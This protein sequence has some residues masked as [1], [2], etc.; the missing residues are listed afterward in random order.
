MNRTTGP[1]CI[2]LLD[3]C[4]RQGVF[5]ACE[6]DDNVYAK[7]FLDTMLE[8]G[9]YG[10]LLEP[11]SNYDARRWQLALYRMCR[12]ENLRSLV[13][14]YIDRVHMY[15][16]TYLWA[17][18]P[19]TMR[20]YL[21]GIQ[22]WLE[23]PNP[24]ALELFRHNRRVHWK[25]TTSH[26]KA[27]TRQDFITLVQEFV[28]ERQDRNFEGDLSAAKYDGFANALW[29]TNQKYALFGEKAEDL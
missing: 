28:Y 1:Q 14:G 6:L 25:K 8:T 23:Y 18:I 16:N 21:M 24:N 4:F 13:E 9:G 22:E 15:K 26:L 27:I 2:R 3:I 20:F 29:R 7:E 11:T 17:L 10:L 19:I 5:D 12:F